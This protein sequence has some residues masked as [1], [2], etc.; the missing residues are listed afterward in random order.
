[1]SAIESVQESMFLALDEREVDPQRHFPMKTLFDTVAYR[2]A[3]ADLTE[4]KV[5]K[6]DNLQSQFKEYLIPNE[7][8]ESDDQN[9]VAIVFERINRAG[10]ELNVFELLSAW[11]WSEDFDLADKFRSLQDS[12]AEHGFEDLCEDKDLQLRICAGVITGET[13]PKKILDLQGNDIRTRFAEI[14]RG[15]VGALD[16]LKREAN[17]KHYKML[18]FPGLLVPLS[19]FFATK[20]SAKQ[21][22][23]Q[24][25]LLRR[26][27]FLSRP[28]SPG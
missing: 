3:T 21:P 4:E 18:P 12:I 28:W 23:E 25:C 10:T 22:F 26:V 17:V 11:S 5:R 13:T 9:R 27:F 8:F 20:S 2:Q 7:V 16:F 19:C 15:I 1:M 14:E 24:S 6:I